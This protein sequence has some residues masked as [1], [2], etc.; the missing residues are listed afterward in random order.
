M[1][2]FSVASLNLIVFIYY[3]FVYVCISYALSDG[4]RAVVMAKLT[5]R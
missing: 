5:E 2:V 3:L 1:Y 4:V